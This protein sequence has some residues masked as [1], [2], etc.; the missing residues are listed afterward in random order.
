MQNKKPTRL[1]SQRVLL[2]IIALLFL[3]T[4]AVTFSRAMLRE[5]NHDENYFIASGKLLA[6]QGLLPYRDFPYS[7]LPNLV[8]VYALIFKITDR[9]LLGARIFS[10]ICANLMLLSLFGLIYRLFGQEQNRL[11]QPARLLLA[12]CGVL[13][14]AA[15]PLFAYTS[16][17]AWS[18]DLPV[19]LLMLAF[20]ACTHGVEQN[21]PRRWIFASGFLA[22]LAVGARLTFVFALIPFYISF[23]WAPINTESRQSASGFRRWWALA[24]PFSAGV[25]IGMLPAI[26]LFAIAP[27]KFF[28]W[29]MSFIQVNTLYQQVSGVN[30]RMDLFSKLIYIFGKL[31]AQPGNLLLLVSAFFFG[32]TLLLLAYRREKKIDFASS[33]LLL[34]VV[35]LTIGGLIPSPSFDQYFYAP[36]PFAVAAIFYG[37]ASLRR[38]TPSESLPPLTRRFNLAHQ[39][40]WFILLLVQIVLLANLFSLGDYAKIGKLAQPSAWIP[41]QVH[42]I[43]T[44]IKDM[45]LE[46][47]KVLTLTP[48]YPL[49][50]GLQI[51]P[52]L[53]TG[54]FVWRA[55][56]LI[57]GEELEQYGGVSRKNI[58]SF[59]SQDPPT[60]ILV[61]REGDQFAEDDLPLVKYAQ[62]NHYTQKE[63]TRYLWLWLP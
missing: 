11:P 58:N 59:L 52:Q 55:A 15:N 20:L 35:C 29:N 25:V 63:I 60:A 34:V 2:A 33:L 7:H 42:S 19:L 4:A 37:L 17:L 10:V 3:F 47:G 48:I 12:A 13:F 26:I 50:G 54:P 24:L 8:F 22:A 43:G 49:E 28:F 62:Q 61:R 27:D 14:L 56:Y 9:L 36:V 16:G 18:H 6:D 44:W 31:N 21:H 5:L 30:E 39:E 38:I 1:S 57:P 53:A 46:A 40:N 32:Y 23:A 45:D 41:L 51:Y